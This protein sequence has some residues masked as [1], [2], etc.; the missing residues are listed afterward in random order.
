MSVPI[1]VRPMT[2]ADLGAAEALCETLDYAPSP[3]DL[4]SHYE[5][6]ADSSEHSLMI[7]ELG[8]RVVG[9]VHVFIKR[10]LE[11]APQAQVQAIAT[12]PD[13]QGQG[14]GSRLLAAAEDWARARGIG[15][16]T[17]YCAEYRDDTHDFYAA[18]GY[19]LTVRSSRFQKRLD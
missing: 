16:V 2:K 1:T 12:L 10:M 5:S 14:V 11:D 17:I 19:D 4:R 6:M 8:G 18:R 15:A 13:V 9:F 7:A 3:D